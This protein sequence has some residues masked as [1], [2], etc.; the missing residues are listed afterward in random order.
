MF[1]ESDDS[2]RWRVYRRQLDRH[3]LVDKPTVYSVTWVIAEGW[4]KPGVPFPAGEAPDPM[5]NELQFR[6]VCGETNGTF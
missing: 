1:V 2:G 5:T 3:E 6:D 4:D